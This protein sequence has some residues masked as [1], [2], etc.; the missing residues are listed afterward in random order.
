[1]VLPEAQVSERKSLLSE[2]HYYKPTTEA[3]AKL[4]A[5][6]PCIPPE[7]SQPAIIITGNEA[8]T[9]LPSRKYVK[10]REMKREKVQGKAIGEEEGKSL[11]Y[12]FTAGEER[13][14]RK[15]KPSR[16]DHL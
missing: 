1:V 4:Q 2:S 9:G 7:A 10:P 14:S 16:T 6:R 11:F 15:R 12:F 8:S 5:N 3:T 13:Q